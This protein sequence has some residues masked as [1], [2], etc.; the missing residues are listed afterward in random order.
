MTDVGMT[1]VSIKKDDF[2]GNYEKY[3]RFFKMSTCMIV[4]RT[5]QVGC[6]WQ[7]N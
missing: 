1:F 2:R 3:M 7:K 6:G 5:R 4:I